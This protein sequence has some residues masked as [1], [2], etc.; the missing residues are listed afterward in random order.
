[1]ALRARVA[2]LKSSGTV[3]ESRAGIDDAVEVERPAGNGAEPLLGTH[4]IDPSSQTFGLPP[5]VLIPIAARSATTIKKY[6][7][8][9]VDAKQGRDGLTTAVL[10]EPFSTPDISTTDI[11]LWK[12]DHSGEYFDRLH[13]DQQVWVHV[14]YGAYRKAYVSFGMPDIPDGYFLDHIQNREAIRLRGYSHPYLRL[15]PVSHTVN[16]SGGHQ[17]GGEG[18]EKAYLQQLPNPSAARQEA[19]ERA[20]ACEIIYADPMDL[21]KMLNMPPGTGTLPGVAD[22]HRLIY[23]ESK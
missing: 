2:W 22:L 3:A 5:S 18:M 14:D 19:F 4:M 23:P 9:V 17:S 6:V 7:G 21:C 11:R 20:N 15:C 1:M 16:T 12:E 13:P 10:I 8:H